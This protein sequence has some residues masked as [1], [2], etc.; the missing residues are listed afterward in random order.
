MFVTTFAIWSYLLD[1]VL[2]RFFRLSNAAISS[3][4]NALK[5][6][7]P[8]SRYGLED[9]LANYT[10]VHVIWSFCSENS[11][12]GSNDSSQLCSRSQQIIA[13]LWG[14]YFVTLLRL[15]D[16]CSDLQNIMKFLR[17][18]HSSFPLIFA[19]LVFRIARSTS[20]LCSALRQFLHGLECPSS[21]LLQNF[22]HRYICLTHIDTLSVCILGM[23]C[24]EML[25]FKCDCN[26]NHS[27]Y[28]DNK[29]TFFL[30]LQIS[31]GIICMNIY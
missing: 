15:R 2:K 21:K 13:M 10:S 30:I 20:L 12:I 28:N 11:K 27:L 18:E 9:G 5:F 1:K 25:Y 31:N 8:S 7:A 14:Q 17:F 4:A 29:I 22:A 23:S 24:V 3:P 16:L 26:D 19:C 6:D